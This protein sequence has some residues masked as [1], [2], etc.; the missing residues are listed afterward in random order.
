MSLCV[1]ID[2]SWIFHLCFRVGASVIS[3]MPTLDDESMFSVHLRSTYAQWRSAFVLISLALSSKYCC[4]KCQF[5]IVSPTN[6]IFSRYL[7]RTC[8]I[9]LLKCAI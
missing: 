1:V 4:A 6:V 5:L 8:S 9:L 7:R 3:R 2:L